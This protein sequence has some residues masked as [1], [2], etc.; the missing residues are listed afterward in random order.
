MKNIPPIDGP[1]RKFLE[2]AGSTAALAPAIGLLLAAD[3]KLAQAANPYSNSPTPS[4]PTPPAPTP[5]VSPTAPT[6]SA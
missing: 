4:A 1:R 3:I 2:K 6:P 5:I